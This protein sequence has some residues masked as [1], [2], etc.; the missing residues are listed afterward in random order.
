[1]QLFG[2][3]FLCKINAIFSRFNATESCHIDWL[4]VDLRSTVNVVMC[5]SVRRRR[6]LRRAATRAHQ[7]VASAQ[8]SR[9]RV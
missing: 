6:H 8:Q 3:T 2:A 1:M 7:Q 4:V 9:G 5:E